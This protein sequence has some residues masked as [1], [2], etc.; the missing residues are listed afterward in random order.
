MN[1]PDIPTLS[2]R[3]IRARALSFLVDNATEKIR[4]RLNQTMPDSAL[5][6]SFQRDLELRPQ[7]LG[8]LELL[9]DDQ[10]HDLKLSF[11]PDPVTVDARGNVPRQVARRMREWAGEL[12][13]IANAVEDSVENIPLDLIPRLYTACHDD[14][15][16][17]NYNF[18]Q[19][20]SEVQEYAEEAGIEL[21]EMDCNEY[22]LSD[23]PWQAASFHTQYE[24]AMLAKP[25][26]LFMTTNEYFVK[27]KE[28]GA[29]CFQSPLLSSSELFVSLQDH[30][31][32]YTI[33]CT[34]VPDAPS[35]DQA[36]T[37]VAV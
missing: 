34:S 35:L 37:P 18:C 15:T 10:L 23:S 24:F 8:E 21:D 13:E 19:L 4:F 3:Q 28:T 33:V 11:F 27:E 30:P 32:E 14:E 36:L 20:A 9:T 25:L 1:D 29:I 12:L 16:F 5:I 22:P 31:D 6:E 2:P 7:Q 26:D 17:Q